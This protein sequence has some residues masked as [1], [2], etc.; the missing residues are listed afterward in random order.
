[1]AAAP[2]GVDAVAQGFSIDDI[3]WHGLQRGGRSGQA[4]A[5]RFEFPGG[6]DPGKVFL[7]AILAP[8]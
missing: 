8:T 7:Q 5:K 3:A 2:T 4:G 6:T 1:M